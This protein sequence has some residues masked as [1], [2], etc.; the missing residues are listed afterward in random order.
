MKKIELNTE[1]WKGH[2]LLHD[3][4]PMVKLAIFEDAVNEA[5]A[6]DSKLSKAKSHVKIIP[7]LVECVA[8]WHIEGF[9]ESVTL[10]T[11]PGAGTGLS[12]VD[13]AIL[14][15][16]LVDRILKLYQGQDPNA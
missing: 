10:E 1:R 13:V 7:A 6:L 15:N 2:V 14:I 9:P 5:L 4:I 16:I 11:F 12:K 8:E 3:P